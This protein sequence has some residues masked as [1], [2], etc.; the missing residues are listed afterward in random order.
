V[1]PGTG[2]LYG[3]TSRAAPT[4]ANSLIAIN[5]T[6]GA[7]T[8]IGPHNVSNQALA[9]LTFAPAGTQFGNTLFGWV[10]PSSDDLARV[11]LANG[12][13]TIVGNSGL[14]TFGG[15]LEFV[16][17]TLYL[18]G[19]GITGPLR[20]INPA[21]GTVVSSSVNLS[22]GGGLDPDSSVAALAADAGGTLYGV[23]QTN[24]ET[25]TASS[26][27]VHINPTTGFVTILGTSLPNLDAIAFDCSTTTPT[28]TATATPARQVQFP[29]VP[30][31][32]VSRPPP[33]PPLPPPPPPPPVMIGAAIGQ[34]MRPPP[35]P[36]AGMGAMRPA[37]PTAPGGAP[38]A[39]EI[40]VIPESDSLG[41]LAIG[42]AGV[43]ALVGLRALRRRRG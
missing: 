17:A 6:N 5:K 25:G 28:P 19:D 24:S 31:P 27:L 16:G 11:N 37:A 38:A 41:L 18:A 12:A 21:T 34:P 30:V 20:T 36:G 9:D 23:V 33:P 43:G 7:G 26:R 10:E 3:S 13:A 14:N 8:L 42:L 29:R 4:A 32:P 1:Q 35:P 15:G 39:P 2:Q 40:P 22:G